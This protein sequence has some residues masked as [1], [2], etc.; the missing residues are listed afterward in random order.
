MRSIL[1]LAVAVLFLGCAPSE[2]QPP[3]PT[4]STAA[5]SAPSTGAAPG[6][7]TP[8]PSS[9]PVPFAV[10][11]PAPD[12]PRAPV[13]A[14]SAVGVY[15]GTAGDEEKRGDGYAALAIDEDDA[16]WLFAMRQKRIFGLVV[17]VPEGVGPLVIEPAHPEQVPIDLRDSKWSLE[18][19]VLVETRPD[20]VT[21]RERDG[22]PSL[23]L[24]KSAA[25]W[26]GRGDFS[27][28]ADVAMLGPLVVGRGMGEKG[29]ACWMGVLFPEPPWTKSKKGRT[30]SKIDVS[31]MGDSLSPNR[32]GLPCGMRAIPRDRPTMVS[33]NMVSGYLFARDGAPVVFFMLGY[34]SAGML[35]PSDIPQDPAWRAFLAAE[36]QKAVE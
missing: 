16:M 23:Q 29:D 4:S 26:I 35:S 8:T 30:P 10:S 34:M 31:W 18:G 15:W 7:S 24:P 2:P 14:R 17:R 32:P 21:R 12:E 22:H 25:H 1:S 9:S 33:G 20:G 19:K 13:Y 27:Q 36:V 11:G 3:P 28:H 5:A 6:A